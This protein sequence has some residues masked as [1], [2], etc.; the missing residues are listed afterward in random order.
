MHRTT[1]ISSYHNLKGKK[2]LISEA[3]GEVI[4][5]GFYERSKINEIFKLRESNKT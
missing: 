1:H 3:E 2:F 5:V 4:H